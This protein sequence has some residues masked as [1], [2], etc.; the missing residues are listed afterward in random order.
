MST[1]EEVSL[2]G[3]VKAHEDYFVQRCGELGVEAYPGFI[4]IGT[5]RSRALLVGWYFETKE[6]ELNGFDVA[7]KA[8]QE[9]RIRF[10]LPPTAVP[11]TRWERLLAFLGLRKGEE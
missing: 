5:R 4:H 8:V 7:D 1:I 2:T 10:G 11:P 3:S 6:E 9:T